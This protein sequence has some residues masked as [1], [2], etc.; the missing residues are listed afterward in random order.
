M[1]GPLTFVAT[2][3]SPL[4]PWATYVRLMKGI[5]AGPGYLRHP[6]FGRKIRSVGRADDAKSS[7]RHYSDRGAAPDRP[8]SW[9]GERALLP[10]RLRKK[11]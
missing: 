8:G 10:N 9:V 3:R 2:Y 7:R 1:L 4:T 6:F 5:N 11:G